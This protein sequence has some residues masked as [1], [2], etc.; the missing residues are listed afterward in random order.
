MSIAI[1][2]ILVSYFSL[3]IGELAPKTIAL[4]FADRMSLIV[5]KPVNA[6]ATIGGIAV[7]FLTLSNRVFLGLFGVKPDSGQEFVTGRKCFI[8]WPKGGKQVL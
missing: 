1:V 4:Q 2:V 5:A 6:L 7:K 3:I 8:P